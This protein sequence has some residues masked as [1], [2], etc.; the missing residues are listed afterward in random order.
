VKSHW[1]VYAALTATAPFCVAQSPAPVTL[2]P[3]AKLVYNPTP[4]GDR[5]ADFSYA[6]Y[7]GGGIALPDVPVARRVAASGG[8]DTAAIQRALDDVS[9]LPL[10]GQFRAAVLLAE[11]TFHCSQPLRITASGVVLRG[12]GSRLSILQLTGDP[13]EAIDITGRRTER[14]LGS[15]TYITESYVPS[16]ATSIEVNAASDFHAGDRLRFT[17]PVTSAW[18]KFMGMDTL[19][20]NNK[21]ETWVGEVI[22][23]ERTV[24]RIDGKRVWLDVPLTD[25]YDRRY[26]PPQGV[27]VQRVIAA[28]SI[29]H[30]GVEHLA[31]AAPPLHITL[32]QAS[33]GA[34]RLRDLDDGWVRDLRVSDT[35]G[36]VSAGS[37]TQRITVEDVT[38]SHST[39]IQGAAKPADF[40]ADG[41]QILFLRCNSAGDNLFYMVTGAR[42]QGPNVL[43]DSTFRGDGHVEPHQRWSTALLI[44][45]VRVPD[46][47]IDLQN[48][49]EMGTGHG[50]TMAWGV[51]WNST[52]KTFVIQNPPGAVNWSIGNTGEETT[53]PMPT[54]GPPVHLA[55]LPEGNIVSPGKPVRPESLYRAQLKERLGSAALAAL[56]P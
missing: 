35:T 18:L 55:D 46:G 38:I 33:F 34:A 51:V 50:W 42:N 20:R 36:G 53:L 16:G 13:H 26:L 14:E 48:R 22:T 54:F 32:G 44:D 5:I 27:E 15:P 19:V 2:G 52:A 28:G 11:G 6:G 23:T 29:N 3:S 24:A 4:Q 25:S 12:S 41:T 31:I 9:A 43:L 45:N 49:G 10:H 21:P 17:R 1:L 40:S 8:D 30:S 47:G 56:Q 37:G 39:T 7:G